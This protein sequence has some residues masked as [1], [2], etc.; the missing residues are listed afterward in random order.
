M[1]H[2]TVLTEDTVR[3]ARKVSFLG[4]NLP[5][6]SLSYRRYFFLS[7]TFKFLKLF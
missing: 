3:S 1:E 5:I 7:S 2:I 4:M 6:F